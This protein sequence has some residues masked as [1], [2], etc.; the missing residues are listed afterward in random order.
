MDDVLHTRS[1]VATAG[2][3]VLDKGDLLRVNFK[4]LRQPAVVELDRLVLE[5]LVLTRLVEDLNAHHHEA[6]EVPPG[7]SDVGV[8]L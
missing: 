7:D 3:D 5:E 8:G 2:P 1:T 4:G 6:G